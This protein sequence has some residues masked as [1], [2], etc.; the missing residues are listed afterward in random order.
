MKTIPIEALE[1][2]ARNMQE[3]SAKIRRGELP[4]VSRMSQ[5]WEWWRG[6]AAALDREAEALLAALDLARQLPEEARA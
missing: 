1:R 2:R 6:F 5:S 3:T 4:P